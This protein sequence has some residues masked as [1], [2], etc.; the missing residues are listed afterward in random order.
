MIPFPQIRVFR[1]W[2]VIMACI[3]ISFFSVWQALTDQT[4]RS[5][6]TLYNY[7]LSKN[8][9]DGKGYGMACVQH[10][11]QKYTGGTWVIDAFRAPLAPFFYIPFYRFFPEHFFIACTVVNVLMSA[12]M[13]PWLAFII[14]VQLFNDRGAGL[15]AAL[16][17]SFHPVLIEASLSCSHDLLVGILFLVAFW[18][19]LKGYENPQWW[20]GAGM[21]TSLACLG[22]ETSVFWLV[23]FMGVGFI[24]AWTGRY[25]APRR[26]LVYMLVS[27][28]VA[29]S[30][31]GLWAVRNS[32]VAQNA[33][34]DKT[35][36]GG[37]SGFDNHLLRQ[38]HR[39]PMW[40]RP[41][42]RGLLDRFF[43]HDSRTLAK[44]ISKNI[45]LGFVH[46]GGGIF[47]PGKSDECFEPE[48]AVPYFGIPFERLKSIER[49]V[50]PYSLD[51]RIAERDIVLHNI[52]E[53]AAV[54]AV[55]SM[56]LE[57][58]IN[59]LGGRI[60]Y[61]SIIGLLALMALWRFRRA[62]KVI[63]IGGVVLCIVVSL[64][65][66][67][68]PIVRYFIG[69]YV[70]LAILAAGMLMDLHRNCIRQGFLGLLAITF[71]ISL[72]FLVR[73]WKN[74]PAGTVDAIKLELQHDRK[75]IGE[76]LSAQP[77]HDRMVMLCDAPIWIY[78]YSGVPSVAVPYSP[79]P[80]KQYNVIQDVMRIYGITHVIV[81][82]KQT[83]DAYL[84]DPLFDPAKNRDVCIELCYE[85]PWNRVFRIDF[86]K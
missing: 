17:T 4:V 64:A 38:A 42:S 55:K 23:S 84:F 67:T 57:G 24:L 50:R 63:I 86:R 20:I 76:W 11:H 26:W 58:V 41:P 15:L 13:L 66:V 29:A 60:A 7:V 36:L 43:L 56:T 6:D 79:K 8:V 12:W 44:E 32:S 30:L 81:P 51:G 65:V 9:A 85:T 83:L 68:Y 35:S 2:H 16:L 25:A 71:G 52:P 31:P 27:L 33:R 73:N 49:L 48:F 14:G 70:F 46:V 28:I 74:P 54:M 45:M 21:V 1:A 40:Q 80:E 19:F 47:I 69:L 22:K 39:I 53:K 61:A 62:P 72:F 18:M 77:D 59:T 78:G 5:G 82:K 34:L 75:L 37:L 3:F 10:Y